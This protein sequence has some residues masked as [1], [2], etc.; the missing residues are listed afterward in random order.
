MVG[1]I[2]FAGIVGLIGPIHANLLNVASAD[3]VA[4]LCSDLKLTA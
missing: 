3:H 1:G 2:F 4:C